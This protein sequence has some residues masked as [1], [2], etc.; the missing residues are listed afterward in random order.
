MDNQKRAIFFALGAVLLWS[1]VATAF[2]LTLRVMSAIDL[3][4]WAS[5]VSFV[6]LGVMVLIR[7]R[8]RAVVGHWRRHWRVTLL[9]GAINPFIYYLTL[10]QAYEWLPA[11]EAQAINYTWALVLAF[12]S[13]PMLGHRLTRYD[14]IAGLMGYVGVL[15][16]ATHGDLFCLHFESLA[17]VGLALLSTVFWA[18]YWIV[19]TRLSGDTLVALF[20]NFGVGVVLMGLYLLWQGSS[21]PFPSV[22]GMFGALYIGLFEMSVT[23]LLWGEA[24]RLTTKTASVANLIFLSPIVSLGLIHFIV[25]EAIY[26]ST[27]VALG[28]ILLG[29]VLQQ[30][31][32]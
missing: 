12:L 16:I 10:F 2:K 19:N 6:T 21:V 14:L 30:R 22:A 24:L 29:L 27:I 17:G 13:V 32:G 11:Q 8:R 23:F 28:L 26:P 3:V 7:K 18:L 31:K 9:L 20:S 1:T 4:W 5:V 15:I 25:G